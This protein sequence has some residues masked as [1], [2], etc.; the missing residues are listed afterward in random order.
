MEWSRKTSYQVLFLGNGNSANSI[1]AEAY[2]NWAGQNRF[3]AH[4]AGCSFMGYIDPLAVEVLAQHR[5]N[6]T[7]YRSKSWDRFIGRYAPAMDFI[8][9][10]CSPTPDIASATWP[11]EPIISQWDVPLPTAAPGDAAVKRQAFLH[12]FAEL[13]VRIN[14]LLDVPIGTLDRASLRTM[15]DDIGRGRP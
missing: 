12:A 13:T 15:I 4:S 7:R 6:P 9:V 3:V 8:F 5:I 10:V 14:K 2:L 1:L 11:G